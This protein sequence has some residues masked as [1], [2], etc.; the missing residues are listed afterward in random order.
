MSITFASK[1]AWRA[2]YVSR[3]LPDGYGRHQFF[4]VGIDP[5]TD[6]GPKL[7]GA[8]SN[9]FSRGGPRERSRFGFHFQWRVSLPSVR[10]VYPMSPTRL[11]FY[12]LSSQLWHGLDGRY[13]WG[14]KKAGS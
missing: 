7:F 5:T 13:G 6:R 2:V 14:T 8:V 3:E 9:P 4:H 1:C 10:W 11:F 12:R